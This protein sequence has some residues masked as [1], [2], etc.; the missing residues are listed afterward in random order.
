MLAQRPAA[1]DRWPASVAIAHL[2]ACMRD[3][4][5][6]DMTAPDHP[7]CVQACPPGTEQF[8]ARC[9]SDPTVGWVGGLGLGASRQ[10]DPTTR[11]LGIAVVVFKHRTLLGGV[12]IELA[13][14]HF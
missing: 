9:L 5:V 4:Y 14:Y 6:V 7:D 8:E 13:S 1:G 10:A 11:H 3:G 2:T 12:G